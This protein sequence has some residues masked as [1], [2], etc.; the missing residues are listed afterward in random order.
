MKPRSGACRGDGGGSGEARKVHP[1]QSVAGRPEAT[2]AGKPGNGSPKPNG[3]GTQAASLTPEND[4]MVVQR[5]TPQQ[6]GESR[7]LE[8][9][10]GSGKGRAVAS[11]H[12]T[13]GSWERGMCSKG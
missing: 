1:G 3:A 8:L 9:S 5:D 2:F 4:K 10:E 6:A 11:G 13:T 12:S 7:R